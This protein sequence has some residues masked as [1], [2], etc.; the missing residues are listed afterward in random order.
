VR[1]GRVENIRRGFEGEGEGKT[2]LAAPNPSL[3]AVDDER[4]IRF[5]LEA[6]FPAPI[7]FINFPH[8]KRGRKPRKDPPSHVLHRHLATPMIKQ[9]IQIPAINMHR[10]SL[11]E[12]RGHD[13]VGG[14]CDEFL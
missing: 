1:C 8:P 4:L 12:N 3:R 13:A 7:D 10:E 6:L 5:L 9:E 2:N 11:L 14:W